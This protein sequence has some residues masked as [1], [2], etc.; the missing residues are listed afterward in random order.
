MTNFGQVA[1]FARSARV[2]ALAA[3]LLTLAPVA[4]ATPTRLGTEIGAI[5]ATDADYATT[6]L[7]DLAGK[8]HA[9]VFEPAAHAQDMASE[10]ARTIV[11]STGAQKDAYLAR[12]DALLALGTPEEQAVLAGL[13]AVAL[14]SA[15]ALGDTAD[16]AAK[17]PSFLVLLPQLR[18]VVTGDAQPQPYEPAI[19]TITNLMDLS[20]WAK[21][22]LAK[23]LDEQ[24]G[25]K[26]YGI[27]DPE[28]PGGPLDGAAEGVFARD[29][30]VVGYYY[31]YTAPYQTGVPGAYDYW[32]ATNGSIL[33]M[34]SR[35]SDPAV[36]TYVTWAAIT[37]TPL[38]WTTPGHYPGEQ[39]YASPYWTPS[40]DPYH[41]Q[42]R[43]LLMECG[44]APVQYVSDLKTFLTCVH[45]NWVEPLTNF[46][47]AQLPSR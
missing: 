39:A 23:T 47:C 9:F 21:G 38:T 13:K 27:G 7:A 29:R 1:R 4:H 15:D 26:L 37:T 22:D 36:F 6:R 46:Y 20:G 30:H 18:L 33:A 2:L 34:L 28:A 32:V 14:L 43:H 42:Q 17:I 24:C 19:P 11:Q 44:V 8:M 45:Y 3:G 5:F 31:A 10:L 16:L 12:Y 25:V 35:F 40:S 41:T